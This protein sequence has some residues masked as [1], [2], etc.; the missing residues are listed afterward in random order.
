MADAHHAYPSADAHQTELRACSEIERLPGVL[1][2]AVWLTSDGHLRDARIHTL[3]GV[4]PTIIS[5]AAA[6]VLQAAGIPFDQ[7]AIRTTVLALP[8]EIQGIALGSANAGGR[9]LL[10]QDLSLTRTGAHVTC[11]VQLMRDDLPACGEARELDTLA[12]RARAAATATIRAAESTADGLALGLEA[13]V[14]TELF[15]RRYAVVSV[16]ASIGRRI[17]TL[18][19]IVP[20]ETSRAAEESVCLAT[21][22]AIDRWIGL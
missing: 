18:S 11:R 22:R 15:G 14:V 10:L 5:N 9:F 6:R 12:G 17:A 7:R 8:D 19:G 3:P 1:A 2:A 13:A 21:L 20:V 4:A 16:E